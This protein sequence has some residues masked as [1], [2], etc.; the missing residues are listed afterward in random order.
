M[1]LG[2]S[3]NNT[4]QLTAVNIKGMSEVYDLGVEQEVRV[5]RL[6]FHLRQTVHFS[7]ENGMN[8]DSGRCSAFRSDFVRG[9]TECT[10]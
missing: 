3:G 8:H 1:K 2:T 6:T 4:Q 9:R 10:V 7:I 5:K